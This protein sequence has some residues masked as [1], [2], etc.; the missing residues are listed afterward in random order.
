MDYIKRFKLYKS[1]KKWC[2]AAI[3]TAAVTTGVLVSSVPAQAATNNDQTTQSA[4]KSN[5]TSDQNTSRDSTGTLQNA[6]PNTDKTPVTG[7]QSNGQSDQNNGNTNKVKQDD[8]TQNQQSDNQTTNL[9]PEQ[10]YA[11]STVKTVAGKTYAYHKNGTEYI[12]QWYQSNGNKYYYGTDGVRVEAAT[13]QALDP[14]NASD[15]KLYTYYFNAEGIMQANYFLKQ[16]EKM[17]YFGKDGKEY[18]NQY[19]SNWGNTY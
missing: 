3:V 2:C 17:Y 14:D 4:Q 5:I 6:T 13:A 7:Q 8:S 18:Q 12:N 11:S 19:Y 16:N 1:G 9:T 10:D 15:T